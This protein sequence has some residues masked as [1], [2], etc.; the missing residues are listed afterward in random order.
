M[1]IQCGLCGESDFPVVFLHA[2]YYGK[3][4][5]CGSCE[6][7]YYTSQGA[8]NTYAALALRC[9]SL[10]RMNFKRLLKY[11]N[12]VGAPPNWYLEPDELT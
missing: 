7:I 4:L 10:A 11:T 5:C 1:I 3:V 12:A 9:T 2:A 8:R 6:N